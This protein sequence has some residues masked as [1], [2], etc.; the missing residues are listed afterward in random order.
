LQ[1]IY[2]YSTLVQRAGVID[3][4]GVPIAISALYF[5][6]L[7]S[8]PLPPR[9]IASIHG[10]LFIVA[11]EYVTRFGGLGVAKPWR[12]GIF[13]FLMAMGVASVVYSVVYSMWGRKVTAIA[14]LAQVLNL[15]HALMLEYI[16]ELAL[17][18]EYS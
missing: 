14:H 13:Y 3:L 10:L 16:G 1:H 12:R 9:V 18:P 6:M 17:G 2:W 11:A 4:Y 15:S 5:F 7:G 8:R